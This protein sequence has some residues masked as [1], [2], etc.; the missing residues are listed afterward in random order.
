MARKKKQPEH[1]NHERW[2]VS[3]ADF[4]TLLF[5]FFVVM[6]A[7]SQADK[8]KAQKVS[9]AVTQAL[10]DGGVSALVNAVLG[11]TV[12]DKGQGNAQMKGPGGAKKATHEQDPIPGLGKGE[13]GGPAELKSAMDF[14]MKELSDE[15]VT[16]KMQVSMEA[17]GLVV[18]FREAAFFSS[19]EAVISEKNIQAVDKV[20]RVLKQ[21]SNPVRMEGHTD[22]VPIHNEHFRNNWELASARGIA[23]LELFSGRYAIP[24]E[25]FSVAAYADNAP[26]ASNDNEDGRSRNRRVDIILLSNA[27]MQG[28][29]KS[30]DSA[31]AAS[32]PAPAAAAKPKHH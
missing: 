28:E 4:I 10:Q 26:V 21:L 19:G 22:S 14:L 6:F 2:L 8:G 11:G 32:S 17:R 20:A 7:T 25:K 12:G 27:G 18:S 9:E 1:E 5:A 3:Y 31:E 23:M 24:K 15:L 16:G 13:G 30:A 29:P